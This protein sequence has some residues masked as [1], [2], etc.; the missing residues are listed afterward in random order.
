MLRLMNSL[1]FKSTFSLVFA[2]AVVSGL[3]DGLI[4]IAFALQAHRVDPSGRGLTAV[5][6]ALWAGRFLSSLVVRKLPPPHRPVTWMLGSDVVR[7]L[8]QWGLVAWVV[9]RGDSIAA[10]ALSSCVY[11]C[12]SSFF[13]PARFS[14]LSQLFSDE[15]RTRVNGTLSML[16]D[17]LFIAGPLIGTAAVL[18]LGF[19]TVLLIDGATFLVAMLFVLPFLSVRREPAG[20]RSNSAAAEPEPDSAGS[21]TSKK[22]PGSPSLPSWVRVGLGTWLV[23]AVVNGFLG[24]A[25]PTWIMNNFDEKSWGFMATALAVGSLLGSAATILKALD[26]VRFST[27]QILMLILLAGQILALA[28]SSVFVLIAAVGA[29]ASLLMTAAG[30]AWDSLGQSL[31][32]DG[33]VH[34]F[35]TKDQLVFTAGTPLGMILFAALSSHPGVATVALAAALVI[36]AVASSLPVARSPRTADM[37]QA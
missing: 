36:A 23:A 8:A 12:A 31:G 13:G 17:V 3:G 34:Q 27:L 30:I 22:T 35:A 2:A 15:Q 1:S 7:M 6:I 26:R 4:P 5:L 14:L 25:G 11:G 29:A 19:N 32:D 28:F 37:A 24:S 16:G 18:T 21:S 33:L 9:A 10:F 20:E